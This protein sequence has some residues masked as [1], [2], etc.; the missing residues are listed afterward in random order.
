MPVVV[1]HK[2]ARTTH[3]IRKEIKE[4]SKRSRGLTSMI[5]SFIY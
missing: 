5:I 4:N 1:L 2:N 3:A